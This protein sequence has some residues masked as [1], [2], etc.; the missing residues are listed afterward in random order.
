M[1]RYTVILQHMLLVVY[2]GCK[3]S[4]F[5]LMPVMSW[6]DCLFVVGRSWLYSLVAMRSRHPVW[7]WSSG[8]GVSSSASVN[9]SGDRSVSCAAVQLTALLHSL[10]MNVLN[11][12]TVIVSNK[13]LPVLVWCKN[14]WQAGC[15]TWDLYTLAFQYHVQGL[16]TCLDVYS[17]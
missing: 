5:G 9:C 15:N 7:H 6:L 12:Q 2:G 14:C 1:L 16:M 10:V 13:M 3:L 11:L 17:S 8:S 4:G